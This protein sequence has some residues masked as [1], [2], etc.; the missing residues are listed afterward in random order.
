MKKISVSKKLISVFL[1]IIMLFSMI[2][3]FVF[4]AS[5]AGGKYY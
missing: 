5:A 1:A 3:T 2:P 4:N